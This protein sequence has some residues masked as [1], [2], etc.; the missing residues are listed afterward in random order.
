MS[1]R[2]GAV[3]TEPDSPP[4][5][6][7]AAAV[8]AQRVP[9]ADSPVTAAPVTADEPVAVEE[10]LAEGSVAEEPVADET[11]ADEAVADA[12]VTD[13]SDDEV[14]DAP[15]RISTRPTTRTT[16]LIPG[17]GAGLLAL[18]ALAWFGTT[19][20]VLQREISTSV[21]D[22]VAIASAAISLPTVVSASLVAGA[23]SALVAVNLIARAGWTPA[24]STRWAGALVTS[25]A[26]GL[27]GALG[28]I[29]GYDGPGSRVLAATVAAASVVGGAIAGLRPTSLIA[30]VLSGSLAVF[31]VQFVLNYLGAGPISGSSTLAALVAGL[32]AGLVPYVYLRR[33]TKRETT[34]GGALS[35]PFYMVTGAGVGIALLV[36]EVVTRVGGAQVLDAV[37]SLSDFDRAFRAHVDADRLTYTLIV[38]FVG[39]LTT[40]IAFG[41]TL[42][43]KKRV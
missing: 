39:A 26:V 15:V 20:W 29:I 34:E 28:V 33:V 13:E 36:T 10:T 35:W 30:A 6:D 1:E 4:A 38:F 9:E 22:A 11:A 42:P 27:L 2:T 31:A 17:P 12:D 43:S 5:G 24:A 32:V 8:V 16:G 25:V 3:G 7:T 19:L 40:T 41:R 37:A 14:D 23:A 18:L 21:T